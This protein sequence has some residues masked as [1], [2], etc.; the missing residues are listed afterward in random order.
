PEVKASTATIAQISWYVL[1][2]FAYLI[3]LVFGFISLFLSNQIGKISFRIILIIITFMIISAFVG[4]T[5]VLNKKLTKNIGYLAIKPFN[6]VLKRLKKSPITTKDVNR[7]IDDFYNNA[8][9]LLKN[10]NKLKWPFFYCL[11]GVIFEILSIYIVFLSFGKF[12]N[13][14]VVVAGYTLAMASSLASLLTSGV[15][16]Y[17]AA[18]V[19]TFVGLGQTFALSLSVV[20]VYRVIAFWLFIPVGL[21]FYKRQIDENIDR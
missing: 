15:G 1:T 20:L 3:I 4:I 13:P 9:F 10:I 12:I 19:A 16:V 17:E 2:F 8:S 21:F 18:M 7:F 11:I 14:G 5:I 6:F